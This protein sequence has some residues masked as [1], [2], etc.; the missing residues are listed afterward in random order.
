MRY[1]TNAEMREQQARM[2]RYPPSQM[3]LYDRA[4]AAER[5]AMNEAHADLC[6]QAELRE[7]FS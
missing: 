7:L 5:R 4:K 6:H 3:E 1:I 2:D